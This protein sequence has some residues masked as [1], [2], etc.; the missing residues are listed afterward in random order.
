MKLDLFSAKFKYML[1][2][3]SL[4]KLLVL[5]LP[6]CLRGWR[7]ICFDKV[8]KKILV[9]SLFIFA[10]KITFETVPLKEFGDDFLH[11]SHIL[12]VIKSFY[13]IKMFLALFISILVRMG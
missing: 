10:F 9:G 6:Y 2:F 1:N 11:H 8:T 7:K 3:F 12:S 5:F 4:I 13:F